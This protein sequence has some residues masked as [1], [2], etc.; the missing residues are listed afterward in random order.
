M[1]DVQEIHRITP[2]G[3]INNAGIGISPD[4]GI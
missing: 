2:G 4:A 3:Y 1:E